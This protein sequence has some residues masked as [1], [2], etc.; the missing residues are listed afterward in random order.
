MTEEEARSKWC[1]FAKIES[2]SG[3]A[4]NRP[5]SFAGTNL[6]NCFGSQCMAWKW[7]LSPEDIKIGANTGSPNWAVT[8][9]PSGYCG[10]V[11]KD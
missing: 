8:A 11:N 5:S 3:A 2:N 10:F 7:S 4:I 1:P 9:V 6:C